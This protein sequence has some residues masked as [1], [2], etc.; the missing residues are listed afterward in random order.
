MVN[1]IDAEFRKHILILKIVYLG[2]K[3]LFSLTVSIYNKIDPFSLDYD[4]LTIK[5]CCDLKAW[6]F[7]CKIM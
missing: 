3:C 2:E 4:S 5:T 6:T 7:T 1:C